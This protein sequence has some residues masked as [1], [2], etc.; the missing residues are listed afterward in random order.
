MDRDD[1]RDESITE[2]RITG[3]STRALAKLRR[4]TGGEI[5]EAIDRR[6]SYELD[7]KQRLRL[8]KLSVA[9]IEG[10][11]LPFYEKAVREKDVAAGTLCCKLEERLAMLLGLDQSP[12][13][14]IDVYQIQQEQQPS[15]YE[16]IRAAIMRVARPERFQRSNGG[17]G[18]A[19]VLPVDGSNAAKPLTNKP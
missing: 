17:D 9:R 1:D 18:A 15:D 19:D 4:C 8:V 2:A 7:N 12:T 6:L 14:R 16:K 10:L 13:T 11:M 5:E 3:T